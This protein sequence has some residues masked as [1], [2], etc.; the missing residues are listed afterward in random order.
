MT[1]PIYCFPQTPEYDSNAFLT[2]DQF[3]DFTAYFTT[4]LHTLKD[5]DHRGAISASTSGNIKLYLVKN[6]VKYLTVLI[7][8]YG[9]RDKDKR[10]IPNLER[11]IEIIGSTP[12]MPLHLVR[13]SQN[14]KKALHDW[15][16]IEKYGRVD[17]D[18]VIGC[19]KLRICGICDDLVFAISEFIPRTENRVFMS[20][21][22]IKKFNKEVTSHAF[23]TIGKYGK[24]KY[25]N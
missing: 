8:H 12:N 18:Y 9:L 2:Y 17:R 6:L 19:G 24:K 23:W 20:K 15:S 7:Q 22:T 10:I 25:I 14:L 11:K 21:F 1:T 16:T 5:I 3:K 4:C 13:S